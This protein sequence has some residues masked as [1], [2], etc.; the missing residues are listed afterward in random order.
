LNYHYW[1]SSDHEST[2]EEFAREFLF[3]HK[4]A[5]EFKTFGIIAH[6]P[7]VVPY[8]STPLYRLL[9]KRAALKNNI[10]YRDILTAPRE[11]F[12][13]PLVERVETPFAHLNRLLRNE[14]LSGRPGFFD[15]IKQKDYVNAFM[16]LYDY[17]K[18]ER[19]VFES[20]KDRERAE[21]LIRTEQEIERHISRL[22]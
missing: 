11:E 8:C 20:L 2:W 14:S 13:L 19:I 7:F 10:K 16:T 18:Q 3:I 4:L 15:S 17:L 1:I 21:S 12:T 9:S 22:L 5:M 6:S